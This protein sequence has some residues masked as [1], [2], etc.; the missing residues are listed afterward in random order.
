MKVGQLVECD[1][2]DYAYDSNKQPVDDC[3]GRIA[4]EMVKNRLAVVLNF[5]LN[6]GAVVVPVSSSKDANKVQRGLHVF[7]DP[8]HVTRTIFYDARDRWALCDHVQQVSKKRLKTVK[9]NG[10]YIVDV[11]PPHL[12]ADIQKG[13]IAAINAKALLQLAKVVVPVAQV[14]TVAPLVVDASNSVDN[15]A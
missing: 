5:K 11:L 4:P 10:K 8:M 12:V 1:F 6:Q 14:G 7:I 9:G 13:I 15:A 2:G 3:D